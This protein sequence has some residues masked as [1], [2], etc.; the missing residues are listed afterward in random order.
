MKLAL[1]INENSCY[2]INIDERRNNLGI[3]KWL[4]AEFWKLGALV[5]IQLPGPFE[6]SRLLSRLD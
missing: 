5:R 1:D 4:I 3:R 2:D 6:G